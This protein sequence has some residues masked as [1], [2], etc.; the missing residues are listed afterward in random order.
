MNKYD[1]K[2]ERDSINEQ[3]P[4][5][6][7][8]HDDPSLIAGP[9]GLTVWDLKKMAEERKFKELDD[10]FDKG[11]NMNALPVGMS[12]GVGVSTLQTDM[13][14]IND[15]LSVFAEKNWRGKIFFSSNNKRVSQGRNRLRSSFVNSRAPF[16]P[17]M[18]FTTMLLDSHPLAP[19]AKSNLVILNYTDPLTKPYMQE[20]IAVKLNALDVQVAVKGKY[21][22]VYI[23]KTWF[24][25]YDKSGEFTATDPNKVVGRYFLDFNEGALKEQREHHWDNSEEELLDSIPHIDN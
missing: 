6:G 23:G 25:K 7:Y 20:F 18:K 11:L 24:G 10:L 13:K 17:M 1:E 9:G 16:V 12:A 21:G 5:T 19:R 8:E 2:I 3:Q 14:L 22:P 4:K 15:W